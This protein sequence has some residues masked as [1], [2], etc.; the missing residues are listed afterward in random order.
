MGITSLSRAG[1]DNADNW[2][3]VRKGG[4]IALESK[5]KGFFPNRVA[6]SDADNNPATPD[7][8]VGISATNFVEGMMVYDTTNHCMKIYTSTNNGVTYNWYCVSTQT[9]PD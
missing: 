8:P 7:V 1:V 2:P 3:M 4:W 5:T 9:C 6:F